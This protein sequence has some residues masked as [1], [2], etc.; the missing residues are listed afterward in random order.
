MRLLFYLSS[1]CFLEKGY[2]KNFS[3]SLF[4]TDAIYSVSVSYIIR[5]FSSFSLL[6]I[7]YSEGSE[8]N[9]F[10][11]TGVHQGDVYRFGET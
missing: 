10:I 6:S 1:L 3:D 7:Y 2:P 9:H 8:I 4:C 5:L 11:Y